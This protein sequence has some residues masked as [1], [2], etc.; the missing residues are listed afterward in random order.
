MRNQYLR[1]YTHEKGKYDMGILPGKFAEHQ[2]GQSDYSQET[3]DRRK[4]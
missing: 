3:K 4:R 2:G 1:K